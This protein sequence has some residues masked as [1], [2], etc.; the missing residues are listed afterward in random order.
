MRL[1]FIIAMLLSLIL[2]LQLHRW[3][4]Q[5]KSDD[6]YTPI[7]K[8]LQQYP[9]ET[10]DCFSR[11]NDAGNNAM[12]ERKSENPNCISYAY[13]N[14]HH[15]KYTSYFDRASYFKI[16]VPPSSEYF[17]AQQGEECTTKYGTYGYWI[18]DKS[19]CI[20]QFV[21]A[22]H[23]QELK[24]FISASVGYSQFV[25]LS[26]VNDGDE[27]L[28]FYSDLC[29]LHSKDM[30]ITCGIDFDDHDKDEN[31]KRIINYSLASKSIPHPRLRTPHN[32]S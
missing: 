21:P 24:L 1:N 26:A 32:C 18:S 8:I 16:C 11:L 7:T 27:R 23:I 13:Y 25:Q 31:V 15:S 28:I 12:M 6:V 2:L 30:A 29:V 20:R 14:S 4:H 17:I 22:L 19:G 10:L 3:L 5:S 9:S